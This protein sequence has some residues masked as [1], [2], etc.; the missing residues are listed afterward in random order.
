MNESENPAQM[1]AYSSMSY[2]LT[3]VVCV[4]H[5]ARLHFAVVDVC[6]AT[7]SSM[8]SCHKL[9]HGV[10]HCVVQELE[11]HDVRGQL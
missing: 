6:D 5:C 2:S 11:H 10:N 1:G 8:A 4:N 7:V 3:C 9:N